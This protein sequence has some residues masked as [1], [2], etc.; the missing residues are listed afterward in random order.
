MNAT[1]RT[2][3]AEMQLQS[4]GCGVVVNMIVS[5]LFGFLSPLLQQQCFTVITSP[6]AAD[7]KYQN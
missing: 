4:I 1:D 5:W 3:I 2:V 6:T 7:T